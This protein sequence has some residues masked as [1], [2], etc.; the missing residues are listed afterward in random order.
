MYI[1]LKNNH[2]YH[3]SETK[4]LI[5]NTSF[6]EVQ[7]FSVN[8][9]LIYEDGEVKLYEKSEQYKKDKQ[10]KSKDEKIFELEKEKEELKEIADSE[11]K[12]VFNIDNN[13]KVNTFNK[14]LYRMANRR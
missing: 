1:Y 9:D 8:D 7:G 6:L 4:K 13:E 3:K 2:I 14:F 5:P 12:R 10:I 11:I